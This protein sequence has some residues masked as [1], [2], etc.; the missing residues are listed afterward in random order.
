MDKIAY[1]LKKLKMSQ[2]YNLSSDHCVGTVGEAVCQVIEGSKGFYRKAPKG[3][4]VVASIYAYDELKKSVKKCPEDLEI[5]FDM[6][7]RKYREEGAV[8]RNR[9]H[10]KVISLETAWENPSEDFDEEEGSELDAE[11]RKLEGE[12]FKR[13]RF[14]ITPEN[15]EKVC[16][17]IRKVVCRSWESDYRATNGLMLLT[18]IIEEED[19]DEFRTEICN[20]LS[21]KKILQTIKKHKGHRI[22]VLGELHSSID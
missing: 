6:K 22:N 10:G 19:I 8:S 2:V 11:E 21:D 7:C 12:A 20:M 17:L 18:R 3:A 14:E 13:K 5:I 15:Q 9:I 16:S 4:I 1:E